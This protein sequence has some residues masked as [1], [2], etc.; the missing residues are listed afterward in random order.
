MCGFSALLNKLEIRKPNTGRTFDYSLVHEQIKVIESS[1]W[2]RI[3][4]Q[5]IV[6][7]IGLEIDYPYN[8]CLTLYIS[9]LD[10]REVNKLFGRE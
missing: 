4:R 10:C 8:H 5:G 3:S 9:D 1:N 7:Q 2:P 6:K